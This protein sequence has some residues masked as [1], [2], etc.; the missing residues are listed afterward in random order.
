M[1]AVVDGAAARALGDL[2][3]ERWRRA[4]GSDAPSPLRRR[5]A[6]DPW[7]A[8]CPV[9]VADVD[10]AIARTA[11]PYAG[12]PAVDELRHLHLDAIAAARR[13]IFLENQYFTSNVIADA[14]AAHLQAPQGPDVVLVSH[15][16]ECG[17]LEESTMGV[18]RARLHRRL[19][20]ADPH[21]RFRAYC[22]ELPGLGPGTCLNVHSKVMVVDDDLLTVGSCNLS[23]RSLGFDTE[24]NLA[25]E[26]R[27]QLRLRAAIA[28]LR[29]RLL[30]EHL[31]VAPERVGARAS[32]ARQP[33]RD[34]RRSFCRTA[35]AHPV[36]AASCRPISTSSC[37]TLR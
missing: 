37:R 17:W 22:P 1:Q 34:D 3:R 25:I 36:R 12:A 2:V 20:A 11:P 29:D 8:S 14:L 10:V 21:R 9:D 28:R 32:H 31:D 16:T 23:N 19:V 30:G 27:G 5:P 33:D 6:H 4:G 7:P 35:K 26:A 24:C 15:R 13:S 18:L